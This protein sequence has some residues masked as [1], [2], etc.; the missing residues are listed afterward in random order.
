MSHIPRHIEA[1]AV[2][3]HVKSDPT[4]AVLTKIVLDFY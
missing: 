4:A 2:G 3:S 1:F